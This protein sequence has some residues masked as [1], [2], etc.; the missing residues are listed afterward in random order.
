MTL[1]DVGRI[2]ARQMPDLKH[3]P[4]NNSQPIGSPLGK[5]WDPAATTMLSV[6]TSHNSPE[7]PG[8]E[9]FVAALRP[10]MSMDSRR[11]HRSL[12]TRV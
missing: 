7:T 10:H 8:H 5:T 11:S 2:W 9:N 1:W 6:S 3:V 12:G 4:V